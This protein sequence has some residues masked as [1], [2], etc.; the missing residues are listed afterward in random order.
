[1]ELFSN[2]ALGLS[3]A[4]SFSALAYCTLGV[5]LGMAIGVLPGIGPLATVGMLL[6]LTFYAEPTEAIIMLA[7]I[8]YGSMYGGSTASILLNLPGTAGAAVTCL[9]GYPMAC[10]GR[11][12]VA[13]F[14]TTIASFFG[15]VV[16]ILMLATFAPALARVALSFGSAEYFSLMVVGLMAAAL[17]GDGS[18]LRSTT[19][20]VLGL[21]IGV[22]GTDVNSGTWRFT[23]GFPALSDGI[24]LVVITTGLF[25]IAEVIN[26]AGRIGQGEVRRVKVDWRSMLPTRDDWRK[27][28]LPALRGSGIGALLGILPGTGAALS[29]FVAYAMEKKVSRTPERFGQGAI[30]GVVAPEAAN[31]AAAQAAFIPTLS[32]GIPGDAIVAIVLGALIIHGVVPGPRL[33]VDQPELFWGLTVSF[34]IGNILLLVL[35]LPLIGL[36][37]KIL[38]IPYR[39]LYPAI[40]TFICIGVYSIRNSVVDI[41]LAG[42]FGLVGFLMQRWRFSPAPLLLGLVLG[43]LM[44]TN[45]RRTLLLSRGDPLV[46]IERPVSAAILIVGLGLMAIVVS[47]SLRKHPKF[48]SAS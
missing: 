32:L 34:L 27:S 37:V 3:V 20:V 29:T 8:Y 44:E 30:E 1:M 18:P 47:L 19:S 35:N 11:A 21:L 36:W 38:T 16:G 7:G 2:L 45:L 12:G 33:V 9:D 5:T 23:F 39:Y 25:G 42:F 24:N 43:P 48:S 40:L 13:L 46:F 41:Y 6:P 28:I 31:N 10:Q 26:N 22:A 14:I 4:F 17:V 15:G